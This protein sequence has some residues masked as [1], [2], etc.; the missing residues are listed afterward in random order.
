MVYRVAVIGDVHGQKAALEKTI[1]KLEKCGVDRIISVGD[2]VDRGPDSQ[3]CVELVRSR[4]FI[5]ANGKRR[6]IEMV[7]GNHEDSHIRVK[8]GI[9][10]PGSKNV[11]KTSKHPAVHKSFKKADWKYLLSRPYVL[12]DER[13]DLT[14][15]HG[16]IMPEDQA[17]G[18]YGRD[19]AAMLTRTGYIG[20]DGARLKPGRFSE[21][22]W[23]DAYDGRFGRVIYGH[24]SF[25]K[26]RVDGQTT[27]V[28]GSKHGRILA[29]VVSD[30]EADRRFSTSFK[31]PPL[32]VKTKENTSSM[33]STQFY[34]SWY[35]QPEVRRDRPEVKR[36]WGGLFGDSVRRPAPSRPRF[37]SDRRLI[38]R[39][40]GVGGLD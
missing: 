35:S 23:T 11:W 21:T 36:S 32:F 38:D 12:R 2:L 1:R 30:T 24:T 20:T 37:E 3:G 4:G 13:L 15:V 7:L 26:I 19:R 17:I 9:P 22:F 34:S 5:A 33:T 16:G 10:Y 8:L 40:N 39:V 25:N 6:R 31:M 29:I 18:W 14:V 27:G 28:D